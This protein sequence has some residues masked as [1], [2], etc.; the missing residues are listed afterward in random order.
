MDEKTKTLWL[1]NL[2]AEH[3]LLTDTTQT[4]GIKTYKFE[5]DYEYNVDGTDYADVNDSVENAQR[6]EGYRNIENTAHRERNVYGEAPITLPVEVSDEDRRQ[7]ALQAAL[8]LTHD[9]VWDLLTAAGDVATWL[10]TGW[11]RPGP[12]EGT[13][14]VTGAT[15]S[16]QEAPEGG[17]A[18]A[19]V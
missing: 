18:G 16:A 8:E 9:N 5:D 19:A 6:A 2:E 7:F 15:G 13:Q 10:E 4:D 14:E 1:L 11:L 17:S 12:G 3:G